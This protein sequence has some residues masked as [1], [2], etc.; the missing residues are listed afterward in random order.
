MRNQKKN[1]ERKFNLFEVFFSDNRI[2][3]RNFF[4]DNRI[5]PIVEPKI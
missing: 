3:K 4:S 5:E 1:R 2:D